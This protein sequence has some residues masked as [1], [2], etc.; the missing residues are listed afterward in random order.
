LH[1]CL[2]ELKFSL[3]L[4]TVRLNSDFKDFA[5]V[6]DSVNADGHRE[7]YLDPTSDVKTL[8]FGSEL[9]R[10]NFLRFLVGCDR[11]RVLGRV[12]SYFRFDFFD[13]LSHFLDL[14]CFFRLFDGFLVDHDGLNEHAFGLKL[15]CDDYLEPEGA[16]VLIGHNG[17][18]DAKLKLV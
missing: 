5:W 4:D 14:W 17:A 3:E 1:N 12:S 15:I 7:R 9:S 8:Y 13:D 6:R 16:D 2:A 11:D 18:I 10:V